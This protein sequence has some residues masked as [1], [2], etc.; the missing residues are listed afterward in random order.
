MEFYH[1]IFVGLPG[2]NVYSAEVMAS[3]SNG[4]YYVNISFN[5]IQSSVVQY[6]IILLAS[7]NS[8]TFLSNRVELL[9]KLK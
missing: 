5:I 6:S 7:K 8:S 3:S 4:S 1:S 2:I 9:L